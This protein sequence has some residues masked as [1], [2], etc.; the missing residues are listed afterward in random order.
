MGDL[1]PILG[2]LYSSSRGVL[3]PIVANRFV[4]RFPFHGILPNLP[5]I[6]TPETQ[7]RTQ[8]LLIQVLQ[9]GPQVYLAPED[10]YLFGKRLGKVTDLVHIA[11]QLGMVVERDVLLRDLKLALEDWFRADDG[12]GSFFYY[13]DHAGSLIGYRDNFNYFKLQ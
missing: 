13:D 7:Q 12:T 10:S 6:S 3:H 5:L 9:L 11:N 8:Q 1:H 4:L 2:E